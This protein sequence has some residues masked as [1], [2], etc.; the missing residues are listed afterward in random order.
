MAAG[1]V[2]FP[3]K[4]RRAKIE[5]LMDATTIRKAK[6]DDGAGIAYRTIGAGPCNLL[7]MHGWGGAGSGHSWAE[8]VK[9]LDM[10]GLRLIVV[11]LRGHGHSD[12]PEAGFTVENFARDMIAVADDCGAESFISVGYSMS[13]RWAQWI[14]CREPRRVAG[15]ILIAPAPATALALP[16]EV[17]ERWMEDISDRSRFEQFVAQFTKD[18]LAAEI[19]NAYFADASQNWP[20]ALRQTYSMCR[21]PDFCSDLGSTRTPTLVLAGR[22]DPMF[23][24]DFLREQILARIP[25]SRMAVLDCGH[26]IPVERPMGVAA[27]IE[28]FVAGL[29]DNSKQE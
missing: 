27:L 2:F 17:L 28:A 23:S 22:A 11:D 7:L 5:E 29:G 4:R 3:S 25:G 21:T 18:P 19:V 9:C 24:P 1:A 14:A 26:E 12:R 6:A 8:V 10:T 13:G 15:Q 16:D 20:Y